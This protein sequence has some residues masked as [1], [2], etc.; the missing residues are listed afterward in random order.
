M[1]FLRRVAEARKRAAITDGLSPGGNRLPDLPVGQLSMAHFIPESILNIIMDDFFER[2]YPVFPLVHEPTFRVAFTRRCYN[3]DP[4][5]FRLCVSLSA[6][7]V[8]SIPRKLTVYKAPG[9]T[10]VE[11]FVDRAVHLVSLSRIFS[12]PQW[13]NYPTID[14]IIISVILSVSTHYA[15]RA[16]T[17]WALSS[18]ALQ[19]FRVLELY[20]KHVYSDMSRLDAEI[21]KRCFWMLFIVQ[22]HDRISHI[23]PHTGLGYDPAHIDWDFMLPMELDD[24]A[25]VDGSPD[26]PRCLDGTHYRKPLISGFIELLKVFLCVVDILHKAFPGAPQTYNLA[27]SPPEARLLQGN[28]SHHFYD[29]IPTMESLFQ[30]ISRL[31]TTLGNMPPE[32]KTPQFQ[33][34]AMNTDAEF[35][36]DP[37]LKKAAQFDIMR[38][39]IYITNIYLRSMMLE[40][41]LTKL[42]QEGGGNNLHSGTSPCSNE[43]ATMA[44]L[45]CREQLWQMKELVAKELLGVVHSCS[46]WTLESNGGSMIAKIREIA[47]TL[48]EGSEGLEVLGD[49]KTR[50]RE[51]VYEFLDILTNLDYSIVVPVQY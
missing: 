45:S 32:L 17:G 16:T 38:A 48:L 41:G 50:M 8:A 10:S 34:Q 26:Q 23:I 39:N 25:L 15:G 37:H 9:Y 49:V 33:D 18:E 4:A 22:V 14:T 3:T 46:P 20:K 5:F 21:C 29:S 44:R 36:E 12:D 47:S 19:F 40:M 13:Q 51:Y 30:A 6:L 28:D 2:V 43:A 31:T 11:G 24:D 42:E 7:T 27:S 35:G 1:L